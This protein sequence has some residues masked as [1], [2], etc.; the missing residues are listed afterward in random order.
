MRALSLAS[1][2]VLLTLPL[3]LA[4]C[5]PPTDKAAGPDASV[6]SRSGDAP[7]ACTKVGQSCTFAAGK[8]GTCIQKD[9]CKDPSSGGACFVCQSQH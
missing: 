9:D 8:L 5:P 3:T 7:A 4:A 1:S 2:L 6:T